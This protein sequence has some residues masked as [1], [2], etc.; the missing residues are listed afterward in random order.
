[1]ER[2]GGVAAVGGRIGE[3]PDHLEELDDRPGPAVRDDERQR[4]G[5]RRADV[6]EVDA[7]PV[8]QP[9]GTA[10]TR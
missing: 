1:M 8:D 5:V 3:R 2:V 7:E 4:V 9:C 6:E 10:A